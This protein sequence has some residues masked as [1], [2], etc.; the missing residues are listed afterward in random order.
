MA[1][2][3]DLN[4]GAPCRILVISGQTMPSAAK[5]QHFVPATHALALTDLAMR[6]NVTPETLLAD[7]ALVRAQ[8]LEPEARIPLP[9][10]IALV[11]RAR[12]ATGEPGLG[13]YLGLQTRVS[14]HGYLGFAAMTSSTLREALSLAIQ[15]APMR[16]TALSLRLRE[17]KTTASLIVEPQADLGTASDV[18]L[19]GLM[20]GFWQIGNALIGRE[21]S[22]TADFTFP[23]PPYFSR[24]SHLVPRVRFDR[25]VHQLSFDRALLDATIGQADPAAQRLA[26]VQC[27]RALAAL[28]ASG[29]FASRVRALVF[30]REK[31]SGGVTLRSV[32]DV[33]RALH[34]SS[35]TLKR[36]LALEG[37][38]YKELALEEKREMAIVL[39][40]NESES[41]ESVA[42][43]V[44]YT[45]VANFTR[46]F[47]QWTGMT[48][49]AYR[50]RN[51]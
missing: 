46:A 14:A 29:T 11:E 41:I 34:L 15:F 22:G 26:L 23:E 6:W 50:R 24:F 8:L 19:T 13:Y 7:L 51:R 18:I 25:P 45:D 9:T 42:D 44:G 12:R 36:K 4:Q 49:G 28:G 20:V 1:T 17:T 39:L 5:T 2:T 38:S 10:F 40:Q 16:T 43:N 3:E 37:T 47:K 35:R 33:A 21:L 27:E 32:E 48:P 30:D 31:R